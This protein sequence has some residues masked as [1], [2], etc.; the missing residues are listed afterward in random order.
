MKQP[1]T[2]ITIEIL[3]S[4]AKFVDKIIMVHVFITSRGWGRGEGR[5]N[6]PFRGTELGGF[7]EPDI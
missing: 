1:C 3:G 7:D 4:V 2:E 5:K 6:V